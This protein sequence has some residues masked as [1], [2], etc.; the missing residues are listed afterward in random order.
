MWFKHLGSEDEDGSSWCDY[1]LPIVIQ[2]NVCVLIL[3]TLIDYCE[4]H[5]AKA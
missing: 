2:I 5:E 3:E 1:I 4:D